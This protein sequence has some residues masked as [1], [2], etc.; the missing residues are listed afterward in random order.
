[1]SQNLDHLELGSRS[2]ALTLGMLAELYI[3]DI[4]TH[5][6]YQPWYRT[7]HKIHIT[8]TKYVRYIVLNGHVPK[9]T[10]LSLGKTT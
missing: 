10:H 3:Q 7:R 4:Y 2:H 9:M 6:G 8:L 5:P 1:M